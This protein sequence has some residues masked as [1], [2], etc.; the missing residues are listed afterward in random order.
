MVAGAPRGARARGA[1]RAARGERLRRGVLAGGVAALLG[2]DRRR[3]DPAAGSTRWPSARSWCAAPES[4][5]PGEHEY[6]FRHALLRE[7]AYAMLTDADRALGH[8]LAGAWLERRGESDA[9][10]L[11]EHFERGGE[12]ARAGGCYRRAAE[13]ALAGNDLDAAI[14]RAERGLRGNV[15]DDLRAALLILLCEID[16]WRGEWDSARAI[17]IEALRF[18]APGASPGRGPPWSGSAM[19]CNASTSMS[20][21]WC[22]DLLCSVEPAPGAMDAFAFALGTGRTSSSRPGTSPRR[23][24]AA[25]A[26]TTSSSPPWVRG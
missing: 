16:T 15:P 6:A 13:Q 26:C 8:R 2:G 3:P 20:S 7:A 17:A 14:E 23:S 9:M 25:P 21:R 4:R 19:P 10:V 24:A 18:A 11:A 12:P 1:A 22:N 5:F